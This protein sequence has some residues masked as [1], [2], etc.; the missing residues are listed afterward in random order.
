MIHRDGVS[1]V[2]MSEVHE[3]QLFLFFFVV[4]VWSIS[5]AAWC[6]DKRSGILYIMK[7]SVYQAPYQGFNPGPRDGAGTRIGTGTVDPKIWTI[8]PSAPDLSSFFASSELDD[9]EDSVIGTNT[10]H[11]Q[12]RQFNF[13][14]FL[15]RSWTILPLFLSFSKTFRQGRWQTYHALSDKFALPT[16]AQPVQLEPSGR[17]IGCLGRTNIIFIQAFVSSNSECR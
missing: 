15:T 4:Q 10:P 7:R 12:L 9:C 6:K 11:S 13:G 1:Y 5:Q 8:S 2:D 17:L 3:Y 16:Y 14:S